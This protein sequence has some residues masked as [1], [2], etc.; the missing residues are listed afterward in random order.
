M[1]LSGQINKTPSSKQASSLESML[2]SYLFRASMTARSM[3]WQPEASLLRCR[4]IRKRRHLGA[5][6]HPKEMRVAADAAV[7]VDAGVKVDAKAAVS[8]AGIAGEAGMTMTAANSRAAAAMNDLGP[9]A[10]IEPPSLKP[11]RLLPRNQ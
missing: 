8:V 5:R 9:V 6:I 11:K 4:K 2:A 10:V 1:N 3:A 7:S